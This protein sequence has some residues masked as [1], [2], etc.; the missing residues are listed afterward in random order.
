MAQR[1]T[2]TVKEDGPRAVLTARCPDDKLG[3]YKAWVLGPTGRTL[4]GTMVPE[5]GQ[6]A[7][8]RT[9]SISELRRCGAWPALE[10][11]AE[12]T[13]SFAEKK[14]PPGWRDAGAAVERLP[15]QNLPGALV[16]TDRGGCFLAIP[17]RPDRPFPLPELFCFAVL[18]EVGEETCAVF[19]FDRGGTPCFPNN[20]TKGEG[21]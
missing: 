1:V 3:L 15:G 17:W 6:L 2:L 9:L 12:L 13:F 10:A 5:G 21:Y 11:E 8:R 19:C 14:L 7:I 18:E 4:L 16:Y 20:G